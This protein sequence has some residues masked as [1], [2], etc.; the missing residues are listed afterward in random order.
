MSLT[1][2]LNRPVTL[3][4]RAA[5]GDVDE[6]GNDVPDETLTETVGEL[7]QTKRD[8]LPVGDETTRTDWLLV[9][10][11]GTALRT[12]DVAIVDGLQYEVVGDPWRLRNPRTQAESHVEATCRR[13]AG[14]YD[15][16]AGS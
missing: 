4:Q 11:A 5:S 9:L 3:L 8:E 14:G 15:E 6:Y 16:A 10:P 12:G 1:D 13:V 2:L 7:Q